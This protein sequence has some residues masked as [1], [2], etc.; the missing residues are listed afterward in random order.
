MTE[1]ENKKKLK[2]D[3]YVPLEACACQWENFMNSVFS[4]LMPY[5]DRVDF[6]T[7]NL[8]SEKAR[9]LNLRG[10]SIVID[11]E[12]IITSS[13]N[14]KRKLPKILEEKGLD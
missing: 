14:F 1:M 11:G 8:N 3:I 5:K 12:E 6:Q 13:Y 2:V 9:E 4:A 10:S 7:K